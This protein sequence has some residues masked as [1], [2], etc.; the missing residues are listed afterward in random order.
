M[1]RLGYLHT[2]RSPAAVHKLY[3]FAAVASLEGVELIYFTPR[4]I[5]PTAPC[6]D[7]WTYHAGSWHPCTRQLDVVYNAT[8][9][10][11]AKAAAAVDRLATR[12]PFTSQPVGD[13]WSVY[14]RLVRGGRFVRYL[15]PSQLARSAQEVWQ[16]LHAH[17]RAVLKPVWGHQGKGIVFLE[18]VNHGLTVWQSGWTPLYLPRPTADTWLA[19][20]LHGE[21]YLLQPLIESLT[22]TGERF[23]LR[24]HVQ[25]NGSGT[26]QV[27]AVYPR[28]AP[29]G[30]LVP[31]LSSG[32]YTLFPH[33]FFTRE[34]AQEALDVQ[35]FTEVFAC[36]L[37]AHIDELYGVSFDELGIDVGIDHE[38]KLWLFEVNW[39]PGPPPL[40]N[41]ELDV[42]RNTVQ[43]A[44]WLA[45][46]TKT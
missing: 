2:R 22:Q 8:S 29:Q 11:T 13:K 35:K 24:A 15:I 20:L 31:N 4:G 43:Y 16:A 45:G 25:K 37:A 7:G 10:K 40:W 33:L 30:S 44:V 1:I 9:P 32:G 17:G 18:M 36:Q 21:Q 6:V 26:W 3:A 42:V 19:S 46:H 5:L 39:R 28:I 38:R 12:V 27:T 34:F 23:D 41:L 14:Q